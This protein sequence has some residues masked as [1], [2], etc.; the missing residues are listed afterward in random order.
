MKRLRPFTDEE[1]AA[2]AERRLKG[3]Y[4]WF[5][6]DIAETANITRLPGENDDDLRVRIDVEIERRKKLFNEE[7]ESIEGHIRKLKDKT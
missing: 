1:K 6:D 2:D 3:P 4:N 7:L 5:L